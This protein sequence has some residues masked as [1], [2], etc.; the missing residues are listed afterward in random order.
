MVIHGELAGTQV[1]VD[2]RLTILFSSVNP[3]EHLCFSSSLFD[4]VIP[5]I[6]ELAKGL[7]T[8][9]EMPAAS[10]WK[11]IGDYFPDLT[12]NENYLLT[13]DVVHRFSR[14]CVFTLSTWDVHLFCICV[15]VC[16]C[17]C[18]FVCVCAPACWTRPYDVFR[19]KRSCN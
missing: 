16:V 12:L 3:F 2:D 10:I 18:V 14:K 17:V 19:S 15:C 13:D 5:M 7:H 9:M 1:I 6:E 8:G 4:V 11:V